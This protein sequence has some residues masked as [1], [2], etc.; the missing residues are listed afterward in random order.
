MKC[1]G[2]LPP[3]QTSHAARSCAAPGARSA[4]L[5]IVVIGRNEGER[6]ARCLDSLARSGA[7]VV[8]V[9]SGSS[10]GSLELAREHGAIVLALD[11]SCRFTAARARNAGYHRLLRLDPGLE[12]VQFVDG[13]CELTSAWLEQAA[14]FL[15]DHPQVAAVSGRLRERHPE[16]SIYNRLCAIEWDVPPGEASACGGIVM[17][18]VRALES[19]DG[20]DPDLIAGEEPELCVRL[21]EAHWSVH[22]IDI[23]MAKHDAD[24]RRFSQWWRRSVRGGYAYAEAAFLHG[25]PPERSGVRETRSIWFWGAILPVLALAFAW[26]TGGQSL[27]LLLAA[28]ILLLLKIHCSAW[29]G[30]MPA[31]DAALYA[32]SIIVSKFPQILGQLRFC[33]KRLSGRASGLIE[34]KSAGPKEPRAHARPPGHRPAA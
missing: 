1:A 8:Y 12:F 25:Q 11:G 27:L 22:R 31:A 6:L 15:E 19:V 18:R 13:D 7:P 21:R 34:Y 14:Q 32:S 23:E 4:K 3:S 26:H 29:R 20:F 17:M 16:A 24:I 30:G 9:D 5:G 10:D 33:W 28:Y 2:Q